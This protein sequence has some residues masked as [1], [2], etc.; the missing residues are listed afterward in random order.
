MIKDLKENVNIMTSYVETIKKNPV[1]FLE[2]KNT[3]TERKG[4]SK[5]NALPV[6]CGT[7]LISS[8]LT[9]M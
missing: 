3:I 5:V 4:F 9:C 7:I 1:E 6:A 2:L 8:S